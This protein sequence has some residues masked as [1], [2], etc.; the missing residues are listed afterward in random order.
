[1]DFYPFQTYHPY[2]TILPFF[3]QETM[4]HIDL[5]LP[6]PLEELRLIFHLI[7]DFVYSRRPGDEFFGTVAALP[8]MARIYGKPFK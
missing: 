8:A 1:M 3:A 7:F 5:Y 6:L 2:H 4:M